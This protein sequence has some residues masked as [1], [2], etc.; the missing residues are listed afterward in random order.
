MTPPP[1]HD[2]PSVPPSTATDEQRTLLEVS[3]TVVAHDDKRSTKVWCSFLAAATL[4]LVCVARIRGGIPTRLLR[5]GNTAGSSRG[6]RS[7]ELSAVHYVPEAGTKGGSCLFFWGTSCGSNLSCDD[8][9][10]CQDNAGFH[11]PCGPDANGIDCAA[12]YW[13]HKIYS[14]HKFYICKDHL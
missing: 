8:N 3:S 7:S 4:L 10:V 9:H 5:R 1:C 2:N 14:S 6:S 13:C 11:Q 12:G